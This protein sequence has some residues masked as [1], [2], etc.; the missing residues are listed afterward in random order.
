MKEPHNKCKELSCGLGD[1]RAEDYFEP[2]LSSSW[3]EWTDWK[4][5]KGIRPDDH[6]LY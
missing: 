5:W 6:L 3:F 4:I 2:E 1:H